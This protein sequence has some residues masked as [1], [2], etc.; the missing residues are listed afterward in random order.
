MQNLSPQLTNT[1]DSLNAKMVLMQNE[2]SS[3]KSKYIIISDSA[4]MLNSKVVEYNIK[5]AFFTDQLSFYTAW[6]AIILA[7]LGFFSWKWIIDP[8]NKDINDITTKEMPKLEETI[9]ELLLTETEV[10]N[11]TSDTL[12]K[13]AINGHTW[14][15]KALQLHY[16]EKKQYKSTLIFCLRE[17]RIIANHVNLD[18]KNIGRVNSSITKI[19][20]LVR[21]H[22]LSL[23]LYTQKEQNHILEIGTDINSSQKEKLKEFW[24]DFKKEFISNNIPTSSYDVDQND[25]PSS[26]EA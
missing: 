25:P 17:L 3:L 16:F 5:S 1:I 8:I 22:K 21:N 24:Y 14:A 12:L 4:Q 2:L 10:I 26:Q 20:E 7:A 9:K 18:D 6:F 19:F 13:Q 15:L 23:S 11:K